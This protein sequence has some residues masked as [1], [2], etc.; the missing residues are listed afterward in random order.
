[1]RNK[2][3]RISG[4]LVIAAALILSTGNAA[5]QQQVRPGPGFLAPDS[6]RQGSQGN[7][8]GYQ[9]RTQNQTGCPYY[10]S[11]DCEPQQDR[12]RDRNQSYDGTGPEQQRDRNRTRTP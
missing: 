12:D 3:T 6:P 10:N 2:I 5:A 11:T 8:N 4:I 7:P 1:M 9:N